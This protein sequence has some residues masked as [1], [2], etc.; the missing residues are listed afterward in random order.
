MEGDQVSCSLGASG[1][2]LVKLTLMGKLTIGA[3]FVL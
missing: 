3:S 2:L 1:S